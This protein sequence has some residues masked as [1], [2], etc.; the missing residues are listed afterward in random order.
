L[1]AA[2]SRRLAVYARRSSFEVELIRPLRLSR[3]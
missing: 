2:R 3:A 1:R